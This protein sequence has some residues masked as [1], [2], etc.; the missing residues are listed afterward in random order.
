MREYEKVIKSYQ[1]D[2]LSKCTCDKCGGICDYI[3][4]EDYE[5]DKSTNV[6]INPYYTGDED[7]YFDLCPSCTRE[8]LTW[9]PKTHEVEV[10]IDT[11]D[12]WEED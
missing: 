2:K 8:L 3:K 10:F 1:T 5:C 6:R 11:L 4:T 12:I 9:F 7:I